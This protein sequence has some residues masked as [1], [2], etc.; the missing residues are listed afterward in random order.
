MT[1]TATAKKLG[2]NIYHYIQDRVSGAYEMPDLADTITQRDRRTVTGRILGT[3]ILG[4]PRLLRRYNEWYVA[5]NII[6]QRVHQLVDLAIRE[7]RNRRGT[8]ARS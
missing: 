7:L 3:G 2:V 6:C 4:S 8:G 5:R 1:L